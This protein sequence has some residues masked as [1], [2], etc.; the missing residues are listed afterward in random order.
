MGLPAA[1]QDEADQKLIKVSHQLPVSGLTSLG[2][3]RFKPAGARVLH[4]IHIPGALLL[5]VMRQVGVRM[6]S[7]GLQWR[8]ARA[9]S[10]V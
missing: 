3:C 8:I 5:L 6:G 2:T 1:V 9:E 7:A 4:G 10:G